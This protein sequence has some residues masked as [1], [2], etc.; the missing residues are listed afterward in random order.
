MADGRTSLVRP[1][2]WSAL[3]IGDCIAIR[4]FKWD[5]NFDSAEREAV[6]R[7]RLGRYVLTYAILLS[8]ESFKYPFPFS[9]FT[10][11]QWPTK[12]STNR[13]T[14]NQPKINKQ[15]FT[16]QQIPQPAKNPPDQLRRTTLTSVR[17]SLPPL[18]ILPAFRLGHRSNAQKSRVERFGEGH[19][20]V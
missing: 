15:Q 17:H 16:S 10:I 13:P 3:F 5:G 4:S 18:L 12:R 11:S 20:Y 7:L 9:I 2:R 6:A 1:S 19:R 8:S 14:K